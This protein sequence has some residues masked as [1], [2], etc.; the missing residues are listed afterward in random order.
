MLILAMLLGQAS[1]DIA[2]APDAKPRLICHT[3]QEL[4]SRLNRH[5]V[6]KTAKQWDRESRLSED[7]FDRDRYDRQRRPS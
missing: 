5:R 3:V 4:G 6:C 7:Q 2:P 1:A